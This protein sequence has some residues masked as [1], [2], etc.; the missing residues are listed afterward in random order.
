MSKRRSVSLI[1]HDATFDVDLTHKTDRIDQ[2]SAHF[3]NPTS[4]LRKA[5]AAIPSSATYS[6]DYSRRKVVTCQNAAPYTTTRLLTL[7]TLRKLIELI[8]YIHHDAT[9]DVDLT[10]KTERTD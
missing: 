8:R 6:L 9:F 4:A 3:W 10:H 1:Y 7:T 2:I 5:V